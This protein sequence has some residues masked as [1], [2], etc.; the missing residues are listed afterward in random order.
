M[1]LLYPIP[2][3]KGSTGPA[4]LIYAES[5]PVPMTIEL[6]QPTLIVGT[7]PT[8]VPSPLPSPIATVSGPD[9]GTTLRAAAYPVLAGSSK[10]DVIALPNIASGACT[11]PHVKLGSFTTR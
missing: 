9:P 6:Q 3:H 8:A 7:A 2:G 4:V 1:Q 11:A 5:F 10:Y